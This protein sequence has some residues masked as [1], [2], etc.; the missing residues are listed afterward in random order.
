MTTNE[1]PT[2]TRPALNYHGGKWRLASWIIDHF[3]NHDR[4][5]EPFCGAGSVL[6]RK[7]RSAF[8]LINDLDGEVVN[9][10]AVLRDPAAARELERAIRLTPFARS[11]FLAAYDHADAPVERA[12]R[13]IVRS[14]M[15]FGSASC[16][17]GFR[18]SFR[19]SS[20]TRRLGYAGEW[21]SYPDNILLFTDRLQGVV[22]EHKPAVEVIRAQD[23]AETL[24]YVDPPYPHE[25]RHKAAPKR[26]YAHDMDNAAH[27]ELAECLHAARGMVVLSSYPSALY[28]RL[29]AGWHRVT[30]TAWA[31][32]A[33][34]RTEGI[35][36]S[37]SAYQA[38]RRIEAA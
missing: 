15:G 2:P 21:I 6:L 1:H 30:R 19:A 27:E 37:P 38:L 23:S 10:F 25:T 14:L 3:P 8:E 4:Y 33:R 24:F 12:R 32:G 28:D 31:D 36:L 34:R 5:V 35:W 18:T 13:L 26:S 20:R 7:T 17:P 11:E 29:Y 22:V 16:N 9:L